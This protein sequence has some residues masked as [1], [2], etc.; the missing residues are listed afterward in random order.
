[1]P[2]FSTIQTNRFCCSPP[3]VSHLCPTS[4]HHIDTHQACHRHHSFCASLSL[5]C[6]LSNSFHFSCQCIG[7][8]VHTVS[9][10]YFEDSGTKMPIRCLF[11]RAL[12]ALASA[13]EGAL[14]HV[15]IFSFTNPQDLGTRRG[16]IF[17][18]LRKSDIGILGSES[19]NNPEKTFITLIHSC[20]QRQFYVY[21]SVPCLE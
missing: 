15:L 17:A 5:N 7:I 12:W 1:M 4:H 11:H 6:P 20:H 14:Y 13:G 18:G 2:Q 8:L 19:V 16:A 3:L 10:V 9:A 21:N